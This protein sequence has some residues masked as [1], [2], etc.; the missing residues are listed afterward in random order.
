E[1]GLGHGEEDQHD[2]DQQDRD[3]HQ[4]VDGVEVDGDHGASSVVSMWSW[5]NAAGG[6]PPQ[7][8]WVSSASSRSRIRRRSSGSAWSCPTMCSTPCTVS[9]ASSS[10]SDPAWV[11]AAA[12]ATCGQITTSPI[13]D[14]PGPSSPNGSSGND[15][16]S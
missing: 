2:Q 3:D 9:S 16:T 14:G 6:G 4:Q 10:A 7:C 12:A 15:S 1:G 8:S 5:R 11:G 13:S